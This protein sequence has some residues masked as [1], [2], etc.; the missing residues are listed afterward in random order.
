MDMMQWLTLTAPSLAQGTVTMTAAQ[1]TVLK[2]LHTEVAG[3]TATAMMTN[4]IPLVF[5]GTRDQA[6]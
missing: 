6:H 3:G 4:L 5:T 2:T 1:E